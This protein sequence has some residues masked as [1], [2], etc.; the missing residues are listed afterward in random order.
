MNYTQKT[1]YTQQHGGFGLVEVILA[2]AVFALFVTAF[3]GVW[4]FGQESTVLS[5]DRARAVFLAEE[6]LEAVR[7]VRDADFNNLTNG[8]HGLDISGGSWSFTGSSDTVG[9]YTRQIEISDTGTDRKEVVSTVT[10]QQNAQRNGNV[11]ITTY[12][13]NWQQERQGG[14]PGG[15]GNGGPPDCTGPPQNRPPECN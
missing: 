14:G 9:V 6:G 3:A 12:F 1:I 8:T 10:W 2:S 13:T 4:I 7:N 11:S 15:G 5:G